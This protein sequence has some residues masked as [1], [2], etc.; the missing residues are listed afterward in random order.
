MGKRSFI[1]NTLI[2]LLSVA[3]ILAIAAPF[4]PIHFSTA[5]SLFGLFFPLIWV[6]SLAFAL[7]CLLR[8][9]RRGWFLFLL[10]IGALFQPRIFSFQSK[11][12]DK[13]EYIQVMSFNVRGGYSI[14]DKDKKTEQKKVSQ[15][16][17]LLSDSHDIIFMQ[18]MNQRVLNWLGSEFP[19]QNKIISKRKGT[20]IATNYEVLDQGEIDFGTK[21]NSC[22]WAELMTPEGAL[23]VYNVH[24]ASSKIYE[25]TEK[26]ITEGREYN[27][28]VFSSLESIF[29]KYNRKAQKRI[30][31]AQQVKSHM[32][33]Y[34]GPILLVG[35]FNE[36]PMSYLYQSFKP[37]MKDL[38]KSGKGYGATYPESSPLLRIDYILGTKN[39][40]GEEFEVISNI[41]LSDHLPIK[42]SITISKLN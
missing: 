42:S 28:N 11:I 7:I 33:Q 18:E 24:Y 35:D 23:R 34:D 26:A 38:F 39:I 30:N 16:K 22:I 12:S 17:Y 20:F 25:D 10:F 13:G 29:H 31:Q 3:L 27:P 40:V 1:F 2:T 5:P 8:K 9:N 4:V 15:L 19:F 41:S 21:V 37:E 14:L 36:T 32:A 6:L